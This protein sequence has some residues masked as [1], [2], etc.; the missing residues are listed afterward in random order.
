MSVPI[1]TETYIVTYLKFTEES[2][3][4]LLLISLNSS[5][6]SS[7]RGNYSCLIMNVAL[8]ASLNSV[9]YLPIKDVMNIVYDFLFFNDTCFI[10]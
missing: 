6:S 5:M 2:L 8:T 1:F 9:T 4:A 3:K 7:C 10:K